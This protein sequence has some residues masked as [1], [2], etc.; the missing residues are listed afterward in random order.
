MAQGGALD[1]LATST[2]TKLRHGFRMKRASRDNAGSDCSA[3]GAAVGADGFLDALWG[4]CMRAKRELTLDSATDVNDLMEDAIQGRSRIGSTTGV[5]D[6]TNARKAATPGYSHV[7]FNRARNSECS[8]IGSSTINSTTTSACESNARDP[9]NHRNGQEASLEG[10]LPQDSQAGFTDSQAGFTDRSG[11]A[12]SL[13][14]SPSSAVGGFVSM[15]SRRGT[16]RVLRQCGLGLGQSVQWVASDEDVPPGQIGEVLGCSPA[17]IL[18]RF[19]GGTW[20]FSPNELVIV[21]QSS[22]ATGWESTGNEAASIENAHP[23]AVLAE[24]S[25][26]VHA[27]PSSGG[28][29]A[30]STKEPV[31]AESAAGM[32]L[33]CSVGSLQAGVSRGSRGWRRLDVHINPVVEESPKAE[34]A[35]AEGSSDGSCSCCSSSSSSTNSSHPLQQQGTEPDGL[36]YSAGVLAL[37]F[38]ELHG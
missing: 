2:A 33:R 1:E 14:P 27:I 21:S 22:S 23:G 31:A 12:P 38:P 13:P 35:A 24:P 17:G 36:G 6:A 16:M 32:G 4:T 34:A 3:M 9:A 18:V 7:T 28:V 25:E 15:L 10:P 26:A 20:Y 29:S 19:P 11:D 5:A 30:V 8:S 37:P